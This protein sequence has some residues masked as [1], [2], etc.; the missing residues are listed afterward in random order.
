MMPDN[1]GYVAAAYLLG[2]LVFGGYW[3][4]LLRRDRELRT[5]PTRRRG[6]RA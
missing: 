4:R 1:W 6:T 3:R 5:P 2:A